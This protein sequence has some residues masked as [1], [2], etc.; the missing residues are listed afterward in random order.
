[1]TSG[2]VDL[3]TGNRSASTFA[4]QQNSLSRNDFAK[5]TAE[6]EYDYDRVRSNVIA[7][8]TQFDVETRSNPTVSGTHRDSGP[9]V[10]GSGPRRQKG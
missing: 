7:F 6:D 5:V 10:F 2:D 9:A 4:C 8:P 3:G 1:M